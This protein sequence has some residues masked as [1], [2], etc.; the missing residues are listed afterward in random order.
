[1]GKYIKYF[2]T[3][4][5]FADYY[6]FGDRAEGPD[7]SDTTLVAYV[8]ENDTVYYNNSDMSEFEVNFSAQSSEID[9]TAE[10]VTFD[11]KTGLFWLEVYHNGELIEEYVPGLDKHYDY[12]VDANMTPLTVTEDFV[13]KWYKDDN[14]EKGDYI[15]EFQ[16]PITHLPDPN[17]DPVRLEFHLGVTSDGQT[18][19]RLGNG[20]LTGATRVYYEDNGSEVDILSDIYIQSKR[21][22]YQ[23]S[24]QSEYDVIFEFEGE[25]QTVGDYFVYSQGKSLSIDTNYPELGA[26]TDF[27]FQGPLM[28]STIDQLALGGGMQSVSGFLMA[29][30]LSAITLDDQ[31]RLPEISMLGGVA[32]EGV[33]WCDENA[34]NFSMWQAAKPAGWYINATGLGAW[35]G[36]SSTFPSSGGFDHIYLSFGL[37]IND[38]FE[39]TI[40]SGN[41]HFNSQSG[42]TTVTGDTNSLSTGVTFYT[43]VNTGETYQGM[44]SVVAYNADGDV[45]DSVSLPFTVEG[46]VVPPVPTGGSVTAVCQFEYEKGGNPYQRVTPYDGGDWTT[47]YID[48]DPTQVLPMNTSQI[49]WSDYGVGTHTITYVRTSDDLYLQGYWLG[50]SDMKMCQISGTTNWGFHSNDQQGTISQVMYNDPYLESVT[51]DANF[52]RIG[53]DNFNGDYAL[54]EIIFEGTSAPDYSG[55]P[56]IPFTTLSGTTGTVYIPAGA[57]QSDF[58]QIMTNLSIGWTLV[59]LQ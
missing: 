24:A 19:T 50:N 9:A 2:N 36:S 13:G 33:I 54:N 32:N 46:E 56:T 30:S 26:Q 42:P 17:A 40:E 29:N 49:N 44:V 52:E 47:A 6:N 55:D 15:T 45:M 28:Q 58:S 51:F 16:Q 5:E 8:T 7:G 37:G 3:A 22:W 39:L 12:S 18:P 53:S 4:A 57:D 38:H 48:D 11:V 23:F 1:M 31:D 14:G 20:S 41:A 25:N 34:E 27:R 43:E 10:T 21:A 35:F 59:Q